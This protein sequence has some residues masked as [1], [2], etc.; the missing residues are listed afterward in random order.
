MLYGV[1]IRGTHLTTGVT[2]ATNRA[3]LEK[4]VENSIETN[5]YEKQKGRF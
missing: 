5:T 4:F 3:T 2:S 1:Q